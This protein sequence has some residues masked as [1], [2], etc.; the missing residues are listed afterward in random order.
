MTHDRDK[1]REMVKWLAPAQLLRTGFEVVISSVFGKH[2]DKRLFMPGVSSFSANYYVY[3]NT[4]FRAVSLFNADESPGDLADETATPQELWLNYISDVGDGFN[5]TY[6]MASCITRS[7]INFNESL[8]EHPDGIHKTKFNDVLL[9]GGD[10]VYPIATVEDYESRFKKPYE[11]AFEANAVQGDDGEEKRSTIFAIPGNHDWYD[12]LVLFSEMFCEK[13]SFAGQRT[14]QDRSY[15]ALK[16]IKGWWLF[17]TDTQLGN[18]LDKPQRDYF[19]EVMKHVGEND[20][21]ILCS[22]TPYW[23]E[24]GLD[25][26]KLSRIRELESSGDNDSKQAA[27]RLRDEIL[28]KANQEFRA[29]EFFEGYVLK[30]KT[31]LFLSGD[32]HHYCHYVLED[33]DLNKNKD[34]SIKHK[35]TAGGG[36]AFLHP[37]QIGIPNIIGTL[38][39]NKY[40]KKTLFP[41]DGKSLKLFFSNFLRMA[42]NWSFGIIPVVLYLTL[43]YTY[44]S[45]L[46]NLGLSE[47]LQ[48]VA[49]D[50]LNKP[51]ALTLTLVVVIGLVLFTEATSLVRKIPL[52]LFHALLHLT[53]FFFIYWGAQTVVS[54]FYSPYFLVRILFTALLMAASGWLL[55][56]IVMAVYL[57]AAIVIF[58]T[59]GNLAYSA[60]GIEDCKNFLRLWID[61]DGK[62]TVYP[63]GV[64]RVCKEWHWVQE[65][66]RKVYRPNGTQIKMKLIEP[67]IELK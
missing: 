28:Q 36:G 65:G 47:A 35:I 56:S 4:G 8:D 41:E 29:L 14:A 62:L 5:S 55:G 42:R 11:L 13:R 6:S 3:S 52:G 57:L 24:S 51:A 7:E 12:S 9:F 43:A 40:R 38:N 34:K 30:R 2:A 16:L 18:T 49:G 23:V 45:D 44:R 19:A 50:I 33:D 37:T 32:L 61:K 63:I 54:H 25:E 58:R 22:A 21:V 48:T 15:F 64:E 17:A 20:Q 31:R 67:P 26:N 27:E 46:S 66:R 1:F 10:E 53:V 39:G 60:V 59:H